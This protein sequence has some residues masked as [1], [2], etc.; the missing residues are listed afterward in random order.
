MAESV[1]KSPHQSSMN[2]SK[3]ASI[4]ENQ[5]ITNLQK[6]FRRDNEEYK[7]V[8]KLP[9]RFPTN[10]NDVYVTNKTDFNAQFERCSK[11]L[12]TQHDSKQDQNEIMLHAIGPAINTAIN[13][14]LKLKKAKECKLNCLTSSI[15]LEDDLIPLMDHLDV[16][17]Q[18]RHLSAV[19]I[20][21]TFNFNCR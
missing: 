8:K 1:H 7:I 5:P 14:A 6:I 21:I 3:T 10:F 12:F 16:S 13:L 18:H 11:I 20:K 9:K 4:H 17:F 2:E 15:E 19:H